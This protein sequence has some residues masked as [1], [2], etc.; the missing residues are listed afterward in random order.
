MSNTTIDTASKPSTCG[1]VKATGRFG[2]TVENVREWLALDGEERTRQIAYH[3]VQLGLLTGVARGIGRHH[4][5]GVRGRPEEV[6]EF[7]TEALL[8]YFANRGTMRLTE[9]TA[10]E[11]PEKPVVERKPRGV[12][13]TA[14]VAAVRDAPHGRPADEP[15]DFSDVGDTAQHVNPAPLSFDDVPDTGLD[16]D[17]IPN[18]APQGVSADT[19]AALADIALI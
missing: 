18:T 16:Y 6:Y 13:R 10:Y 7:S 4:N 3:L 12:K 17:N 5:P 9:V 14:E 19:I 2:A 8:T 1:T 15:L 11:P